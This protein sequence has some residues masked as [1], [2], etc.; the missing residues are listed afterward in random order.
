MNRRRLPFL[1]WL[2]AAAVV[3]ALMV[4]VIVTIVDQGKELEDTRNDRATLAADLRT[5]RGQVEA[6]GQEPAAPPPEERVGEPVQGETGP[7]GE[8]GPAGPSGQPGI[9]GQPGA[10]GLPGPPGEQGP[11]GPAGAPGAQGA[12]G[13]TGPAGPAG[14]A[15]ADGMDGAT[16]PQGETGAQGPAG[17][18]GPAGPQGVQGPQGAQGPPVGSFTFSIGPRNFLCQDPEQDGLFTCEAV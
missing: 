7:R 6:L 14:P 2:L 1:A 3:V 10:R 17:P 4:W 15:G 11:V 18:E 16:G 9:A 8:P 5:V 13:A 12:T